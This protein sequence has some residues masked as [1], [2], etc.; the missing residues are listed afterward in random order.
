MEPIATS[1]QASVA[2]LGVSSTLQHAYSES[3]HN[4]TQSENRSKTDF[5]DFNNGAKGKPHT[6]VCLS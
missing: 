5:S 4:H 2:P 1:S 6:S 3:K